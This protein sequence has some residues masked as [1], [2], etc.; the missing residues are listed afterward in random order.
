MTNIIPVTNVYTMLYITL[1]S[2]CQGSSSL[3]LFTEN[4]PEVELP[5]S[6]KIGLSWCGLQRHG[7]R[8]VKRN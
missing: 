5:D 1:A 7:E 6:S 2:A 8:Q 4:A 3:P